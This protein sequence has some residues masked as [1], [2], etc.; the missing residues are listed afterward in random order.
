M[1]A[2][3]LSEGVVGGAGVK[4]VVVVDL[5]EG[6]DRGCRL[7]VGIWQLETGRG[8]V[9]KQSRGEARRCVMQR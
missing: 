4:V 9:G 3:A 5:R 1:H 2:V 8:L 7:K 6:V